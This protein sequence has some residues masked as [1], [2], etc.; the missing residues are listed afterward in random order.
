[1]KKNQNQAKKYPPNYKKKEETIPNFNQGKKNV[2]IKDNNS[3]LL[4]FFKISSK[5]KS[6]SIHLVPDTRQSFIN[7]NKEKSESKKNYRLSKYDFYKSKRKKNLSLQQ[8]TKNSDENEKKIDTSRFILF[9]ENFTNE[10]IEIFK[11]NFIKSFKN[12]IIENYKEEETG[13]NKKPYIS[14][15]SFK[16]FKNQIFNSFITKY[17]LNT[18]HNLIYVPE[19]YMMQNNNKN[20]LN[21]IELLG[22]SDKPNIFLEY[23]PININES[24]Y[25]YPDL[26]SK[27]ENYIKQFKI[28]K[29]KNKPNRALLL[30]RPNDDFTSYINKI[31]LVC[32]QLGYRLLIRE[33][34][35]NKLINI[36]KLKEINQNYI[37]GSLQDNNIKYLKILDNI[38]IT[39]KWTNFLESNNIQINPQYEEELNKKT[40]TIKN[41]NLSKTQSTIEATQNR[42]IKITV[43]KKNSQN[44][45]KINFSKTLTF[46]GHSNS[47]TIPSQ[48]SGKHNTKEFK[49]F[50]NYQQNILEKFNKRRNVILFVD[51]FE[52]NDDNIKY[53]NQINNIIPTSK[54]PIIILT[55][56]LSLFTD[57]TLIGNN[58]FQT[59]YLPHQIENEGIKQKENVIYLTFF[60]LYFLLFIP[61]AIFDTKNKK[62]EKFINI[63]SEKQK[64]IEKGKDNDKNKDKELENELDFVIHINDSDLSSGDNNNEIKNSDLELIKKSINNI[65]VDIKLKSSRNIIYYNLINLSNA[66]S[67]INNYEIDNI[68]VYLKNILDPINIQ[69]KE[70]NVLGNIK[71]SLL[72]KYILSDIEKYKMQEDILFENENNLN[73]DISTLSEIYEKNSFLDFEFGSINRMAE[74]I[75]ERKLKYF[76]INEGIDYNKESYFFTDKYCYDYKY[77][78]NFN[79]ITN[80]EIEQRI[81]EDHQ[82]YHRYY[83]DSSIKLNNSD[84]SKI[85]IL[86]IQIINNDRI[87]IGDTSKFIGARYSKRKTNTK[88]NLNNNKNSLFYEKISLLNRLFRKCPIELFT[89]YINAH[90]GFHYYNELNIDGQKYFIPEKLLFYNYYNDYYIMET[91]QSEQ[92]NK[93]N[94]SEEDEDEVNDNDSDDSVEDQEDEEINEENEDED[95]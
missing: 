32:S 55:N 68:L 15:T 92:K 73:E 1:M 72:Q 78:K 13:I 33:D 67:I 7:L 40:N 83:N 64:D 91:I 27:I 75:Y 54:S 43:S 11:Q 4:Q 70:Q 88:N 52:K 57:N 74:N 45:E 8:L 85:N 61:K 65:Y 18:Y 46:I 80:E 66:I 35:I 21:E 14:E 51:N 95:Y 49:I 25:F 28:K 81:R 24:S 17:L 12:Y 44:N 60:I 48:E 87:T 31:K 16:K 22:Y 69:L 82:F 53:I 38:S 26:C 37:I 63:K 23:S 29:K 94:E 50:Q 9:N 41:K 93:Y 76:D 19:K 2:S 58:S 10:I 71:I 3:T 39:E 5:H 20:D 79:Y 36:D 84:I 56:N 90:F 77:N 6:S 30:Y 86:L 34:E 47:D 42:T 62:E 89:R 59:R